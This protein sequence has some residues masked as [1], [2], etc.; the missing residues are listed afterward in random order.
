MKRLL[1]LIV[2]GIFS[3]QPYSFAQDFKISGKSIPELKQEPLLVL[4]L[5]S[6]IKLFNITYNVLPSKSQAA[7]SLE[8]APSM[9]KAWSYEELAFFCKL[10]V[11]MEKAN[12]FP[13][14]FRLGEVQYVERLEG[15]Y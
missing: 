6:N 4:T 14:K 11:K 5:P 9:P 3:I 13:I 12:R 2:F 7:S 8:V 15:K 10:E 1:W